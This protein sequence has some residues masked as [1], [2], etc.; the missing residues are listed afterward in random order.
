MKFLLWMVVL[1]G[2]GAGFLAY[3]SMEVPGGERR[4]EQIVRQIKDRHPDV[5]PGPQI[6]LDR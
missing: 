1:G 5:I 3:M 6:S 2:A 4:Y